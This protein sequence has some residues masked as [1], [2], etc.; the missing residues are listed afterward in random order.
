MGK[1]GKTPPPHWFPEFRRL[2]PA[3]PA[4]RRSNQEGLPRP[5]KTNDFDFGHSNEEV[6]RKNSG[7]SG[8]RFGRRVQVASQQRRRS[9][10]QKV[11]RHQAAARRAARKE[12]AGCAGSGGAERLARLVASTH[13]LAISDRCCPSATIPI[14]HRRIMRSGGY[15]VRRLLERERNIGRSARQFHSF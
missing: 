9:R 13:R 6:R 4:G 14:Q 3:V 15:D 12:N 8:R 7:Q 11:H 1:T 10:K 2:H 5:A